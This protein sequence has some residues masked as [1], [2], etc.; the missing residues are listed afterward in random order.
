[1]KKAESPARTKFLCSFNNDQYQEIL[2]YNDIIRHIQKDHNDIDVWKFKRMTAHEGPILPYQYNY[3]GSSYNVMIE[4]E[5]GEIT[6]EPLGIISAD[7]P[8]TCAIYAKRQK[9]FD[10]PG[11]R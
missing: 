2:A 4:W 7:D 5:T 8:V 10:T 11:W 3:K 9:L 6:T 1:M